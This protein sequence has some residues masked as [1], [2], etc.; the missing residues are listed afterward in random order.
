MIHVAVLR[1]VSTEKNLFGG[2]NKGILNTRL[3]ALHTEFVM[4]SNRGLGV[5]GV[6]RYSQ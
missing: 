5:L 6:M 2:D 1:S 3:F 4:A